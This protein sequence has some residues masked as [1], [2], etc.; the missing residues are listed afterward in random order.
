MPSESDWSSLVSYLGG[1]DVAGGKLK[2]QGL[3]Y[4]NAPNENATNES[5]SSALPA[6][7]RH[8]NG[9][10]DYEYI[11]DMGNFWSTGITS[12]TNGLNYLLNNDS[13]YINL[14]LIHI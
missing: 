11:G 3:N 14:S 8:S 12:E 2:Q 13:G 5:G 9:G 7:T 4:W 1:Q 10:L 6:G